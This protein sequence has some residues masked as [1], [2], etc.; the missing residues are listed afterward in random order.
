[1]IRVFVHYGKAD[2]VRG[3]FHIY[4]NSQ[5]LSV[6]AVLLG[7]LCQSRPRLIEK[8]ICFTV[9]DTARLDSH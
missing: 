5:G 8:E 3:E 2:P 6:I 1:M 9:D 7:R 4:L